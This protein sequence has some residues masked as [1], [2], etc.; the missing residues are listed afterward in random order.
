MRWGVRDEATV[1]HST[2]ALCMNEI[3]NSK[4]LSIGPTFVVSC[5]RSV[6]RIC[7]V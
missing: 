5:S 3:D 7:T 1:D 2:S 4:K 6:Q